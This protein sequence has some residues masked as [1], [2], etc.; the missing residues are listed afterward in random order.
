[1]INEPRNPSELSRG[2]GGNYSISHETKISPKIKRRDGMLYY[3]HPK[4]AAGPISYTRTTKTVRILCVFIFIICK[5]IN[6]NSSADPFLTGCAGGLE[7]KRRPPI[8][9]MTNP[10]LSF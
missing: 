7:V 3:V 9:D 4:L 1:M 2:G 5:R 8:T 6:D 10:S